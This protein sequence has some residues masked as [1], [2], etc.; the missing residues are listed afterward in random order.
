MKLD[1]SGYVP[2]TLADA[3]NEH[4]TVA[5]HST[6]ESKKTV[7]QQHI[8]AIKAQMKQDFKGEYKIWKERHLTEPVSGSFS[9]WGGRPWCHEI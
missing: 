2:Q 9:C 1:Y 6:N 7:A 8:C 5:K 3:Y 4:I